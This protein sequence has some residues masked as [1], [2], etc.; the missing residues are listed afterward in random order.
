MP[1]G[2]MTIDVQHLIRGKYIIKV[3]HASEE[4]WSAPFLKL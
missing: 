2:V 3:E 1:A 4:I